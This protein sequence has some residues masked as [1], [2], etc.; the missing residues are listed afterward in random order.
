M[1][2][3]PNVSFRC[4]DSKALKSLILLSGKQCPPP[5]PHLP[6]IGIGLAQIT[7]N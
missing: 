1:Y 3:D 6:K 4:L 2:S 5:P 7:P